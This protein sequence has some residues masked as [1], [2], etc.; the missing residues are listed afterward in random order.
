MGYRGHSSPLCLWRRYLSDLLSIWFSN[1]RCRERSWFGR[2]T[3]QLYPECR[4][5]HTEKLRRLRP[6]DRH[7]HPIRHRTESYIATLHVP[8]C[9]LPARQQIH[10]R[11]LWISQFVHLNHLT[12]GRRRHSRLRTGR[13]N[14]PLHP[15]SGSIYRYSNILHHS[16]KQNSVLYPYN[17]P[18]KREIQQNQPHHRIQYNSLHYHFGRPLHGE[19]CYRA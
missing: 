14:A 12:S 7:R 13:R 10:S 11:R 17:D 19:R 2:Q 15:F 4:P 16:R 6:D 8:R 3:K 9:T 18:D 1:N 5:K